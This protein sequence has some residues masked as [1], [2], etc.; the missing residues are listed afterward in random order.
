MKI[1][2]LIRIS[3]P[4]YIKNKTIKK[5][6]L[7]SEWAK[8]SKRP[9]SKENIE[10]DNKVLLNKHHDKILNIICHEGNSNLNHNEIALHTL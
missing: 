4:E 5:K 7:N 9:F 8:H 1:I 10:V 3:Y 2:Y 6:Q